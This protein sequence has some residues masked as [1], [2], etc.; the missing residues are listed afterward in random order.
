METQSVKRLMSGGATRYFIDIA[1]AAAVFATMWAR[2]ETTP[3]H[4]DEVAWIGYSYYYHLLFENKDATSQD[5]QSY[6]G[7]CDFPMGKY[8]YGLGLTLQEHPVRNLEIYE[9]FGRLWQRPKELFESI[10]VDILFAARSVACVFSTLFV[11]LVYL[12]TRRAAGTA[13][14]IAASALLI[15]NPISVV[16]TQALADPILLA[17]LA[18]GGLLIS[19]WRR[20][21]EEL[22][23]RR[24]WLV[25]L[26]AGLLT[27]MAAAIKANGAILGIFL[28]LAAMWV[29][30]RKRSRPRNRAM[31]PIAV[32]LAGLMAFSFFIVINPTLY[33]HPF[34]GIL[35]FLQFRAETIA[36]QQAQIG[37]AVHGPIQKIGIVAWRVLFGGP[38]VAFRWMG[39]LSLAGLVLLIKRAAKNP[40]GGE[41][42]LI[43]WCFLMYFSTTAWI[44]LDWERY[45]LP[46][47][48][49]AAVSAGTAT[50]II[51][52]T[53]AKSL[54]NLRRRP[55]A[56]P[57]A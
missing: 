42:L 28:A 8:L 5:W 17:C 14:G 26:G 35:D 18:G 23:G 48:T 29:A 7:R 57:K 24:L 9:K 36:S 16:Y 27:G 44:P 30:I 39:L 50:G 3:F 40:R 13:A 49:A 2:I 31:L 52:E 1:M 51:F 11:W 32:F 20:G 21:P 54:L 10:P 47:A 12:L 4:I 46:A 6:P 55:S 38:Y 22:T 25:T 53:A 43:I 33:G 37:P 45:Y 41:V 56:D 34:Q 15:F 19:A